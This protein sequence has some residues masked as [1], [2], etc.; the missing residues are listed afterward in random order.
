MNI[1]SPSFLR[2]VVSAKFLVLTAVSVRSAVNLWPLDGSLASFTGGPPLTAT[3]FTPV[4]AAATF[5]GAPGTVLNLPALPPAQSLRMPNNNGPNGGGTKTNNWTV[6]MD[7][8]TP[9]A[10][11]QWI[12][13][14]QTNTANSDDAEVFINNTGRLWAGNL[15]G[16][17]GSITTST[18][19]RIGVRAQVSGGQ[20]QLG[21]FL[22]GAIQP[23][24]V[25]QVLDGNYALGSAALLFSDNN[26][27]TAAVSVGAVAF[28]NESLSDAAMLALGGPSG[29]GIDAASTINPNKSLAWSANGVWINARTSALTNSTGG[30]VTAGSYVLSGKMWS[31]NMGWIDTGDGSPA[32]GIR[33]QNAEVSGQPDFG[34]N[35]DGAGRLYGLAWGQNIGWVNFG[36]ASI[37]QGVWSNSPRLDLNTGAITGL[38]WRQNVGWINLGDTASPTL[39]TLTIQCGVDTDNDGI[40]DAWEYDRD[41]R[42][43]PN[44]ARLS[45]NGDFDGDGVSDAKEYLAD[46]SPFSASDFLAYDSITRTGTVATLKWKSRPTRIYQNHVSTN[47]LSWSPVGSP[48]SGEGLVLTAAFNRTEPRL[49]FRLSTGCPL[50]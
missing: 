15:A 38:A 43:G 27:E 4:Y 28:W 33:Y 1:H 35:H 39:A 44:L 11:P 41:G 14:L 34:V 10:L 26:S 21:L 17:A 48:F 20:I 12:A 18:W 5:G 46:T 24:P 29:S 49:Y 32:N 6:V 7:V 16:S 47:L 45:A 13:L 50:Q 31:A 19:Y 42:L 9:A 37:V 22:N 3:G 8:K 2:R 40:A 30:G 36:P 25:S 23:G